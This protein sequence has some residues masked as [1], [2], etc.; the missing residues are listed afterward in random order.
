MALASYWVIMT[1]QRKTTNIILTLWFVMLLVLVNV[2]DGRAQCTSCD[3]TISS[4]HSGSLSLSYG[5]R[6]C[7]TSTGSVTGSVS[8][9]GNVN[10]C[11]EGSFTPS[12]LSTAWGVSFDNGGTME[13]P[14]NINITNY[15]NNSGNLTVNGNLTSNSGK[16]ISNT[17]SINVTGYLS[18][19][20]DLTNSGTL[21]VDGYYNNGKVLVNT[22]AIVV[23]GIF[24]NSSSGGASGTNSGTMTIGD[25]FVNQNPF[26]N[27][28]GGVITVADDFN[29]SSSGG[30]SFTNSGTL[31]VGDDFTN[32]NDLTNNGTL[33][34]SGDFENSNS[35][36]ASL[37]N[38]GDFEVS[39]DFDNYQRFTNNGEALIRGDFTQTNVGSAELENDSTLTVTGDVNSNNDI[40]NTGSMIVGGTFT[41]DI[42]S[43]NYQAEPNSLLVVDSFVNRSNI[44]SSST[45]YGQIQVISYAENSGSVGTR[46]D[47]CILS[48]NGNWDSNT[49]T[50]NANVVNCTQTVNSNLVNLNINV[51]LEACYSTSTDLM[52]TQLR[53]NKRLPTK[54]PFKGGPWGWNGTESVEDSVADISTD[55]VDWVMIE[56][57]TST[58]ASSKFWQKCF[59]LTKSGQLRD[60]LGNPALIE[61]PS[62]SNFYVVVTA[63]N[64][65]G[66]M[67]N[68]T[69]S[70]QGGAIA[71]DFTTG[72]NKAYTTGA[73]PMAELE[74]GVFGLVSGDANG[75]GTINGLDAM[76]WYNNS[77]ATDYNT[78][79]LNLDSQIDNTDRDIWKSKNGLSVQYPLN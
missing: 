32:T 3:V 9:A 79:D 62:E 17:S 73:A 53:G 11:N 65:L 71:Y 58:S 38:N 46:V 72:Q 36:G 21:E 77:G 63:R 39:G 70:V 18:N 66:V 75:D 27:Q 25:D 52:T 45:D 31:T 57:R 22:G 15:L 20:G 2:Q 4:T 43:G 48:N 64:H 47:V 69:V 74:P 6:L 37:T 30:A 12:T 29:N 67:S 54:Q 50:V 1:Q 40:T 13:F 76:Y 59:F 41:N 14:S 68:Q 35:G 28:L 42:W 24:T 7:I 33:N 34:V 56:F 49:G 16:P 8:L 55:I 44:T 23:G 78:A 51:F 61:A 19:Q 60:G 26:N 5:Q 10:V